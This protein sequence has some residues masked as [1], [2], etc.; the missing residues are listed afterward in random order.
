M[1]VTMFFTTGVGVEGGVLCP[2]PVYKGEFDAMFDEGICEG[3]EEGATCVTI[4]PTGTEI[5]LEKLIQ[6]DKGM[7][8]GVKFSV[9]TIVWT[10]FSEE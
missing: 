7:P 5:D 10:P 6:P 2:D 8:A 3:E 1:S 4:I 9:G